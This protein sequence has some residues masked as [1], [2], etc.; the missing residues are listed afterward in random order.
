MQS[1]SYT[2]LDVYKR[3][4]TSY[5]T[6]TLTNNDTITCELTSNA[7]CNSGIAISNKVV[8]IV[9]PNI[10]P[11]ISISTPTSNVCEGIN[12]VFTAT[13]INGGTSPVYQW[14]KNGLDVGTNDTTYSDNGLLDGDCL[15]YTS[16]CV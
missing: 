2:H 15:L 1:V 14:K 12:V 11:Q 8:M 13:T 6:N 9:N 16:R 4:G 5:T 10:V 3:Q 7:V